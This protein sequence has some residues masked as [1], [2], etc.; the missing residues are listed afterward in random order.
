MMAPVSPRT[1][2]FLAAL[3]TALGFVL[4]FSVAATSWVMAG[5]LVMALV[6]GR[7]WWQTRAWRE[8]VMLIGLALLVFIA[9]RSVGQSAEGW[10]VALRYR[11]LAFAMV[12][13]GLF[14]LVTL[15]DGFLVGLAAGCCVYA[16]V[17]WAGLFQ[18]ELAVA[19]QTH[20]ISAGFAFAVTAF[21]ML[22][23]AG[24]SASPRVWLA[25]AAFLAISV[26]FAV[27]GRTGYVTLFVL[28]ACAAWMH[29]PKQWRWGAVM[30][31]PV[32]IGLLALGSGPA[33]ERFVESAAGSQP[34]ADGT[35]SGTGIRI[36][37]VRNSAE[38]ASRYWRH[39]AGYGQYSRVHRELAQERYGADPQRRHYLDQHWIASENPHSEYVMQ[40]VGGGAAG[41]ALFL[42]WM[43]APVVRP[44]LSRDNRATLG[45]VALA[46]AIGCLFNSMLMDFV[47]AHFYVAVLAWLL[48]APPE[49]SS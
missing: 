36:E 30:A 40:L 31:V 46:F 44:G 41:L 18:P 39:G 42:A 7:A 29:S 27:G 6:L 12:L 23:H 21:L 49:T 15:R 14:R 16:A 25:G 1:D 35:L 37:L 45:W 11:E 34:M 20:R 10:S 13:L 47:E 19:I 33:R 3:L 9:V 26:L 8:P 22:R 5:L 28:A 43:V 38:L 17:H 48:S 4:P 24:R 2:L 32:V